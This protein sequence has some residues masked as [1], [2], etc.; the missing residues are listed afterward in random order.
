MKKLTRKINKLLKG[1]TFKPITIGMSGTEVYFIKDL[2]NFGNV[3]LKIA[4]P[5]SGI[6]LKH[7]RDVLVWLKDKLNVP[8]VIY[9]EQN[10][11]IDYLLISAIEGG[12]ISIFTAQ[13]TDNAELI[14]LVAIMAKEMRKIHETPI[15]NCPFPQ[16]LLIK[17]QEAKKRI[18][19]GLVDETD[20][21]EEN[22][23]KTANEI[24]QKLINQNIGDEDLVFTHGDFCLP[25]FIIKNKQINGIIDWERG[26]ISDRYQDIALFLRSFIFIFVSGFTECYQPVTNSGLPKRIKTIAVPAFQFEAKGLRYRVETRFTEAVMK[27]IIKRSRGLKVQSSPKGADAVVE[28]NIRDFNFTG[29]LLDSAVLSREELRTQ[30]KNGA[31]APLYLFFG[32]EKYLRDLAAKTVTDFSLR[33]SAL[34]EFNEMEFSLID[35]EFPHAIAAAE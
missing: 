30:L 24:Y 20:F 12:D 14:D 8:E 23:G 6:D 29:V 9:F 21:L 13:N 5:K 17:F 1:L 33:D 28:G 25:N 11:E 3:Y 31:I 26:G 35:T 16:N 7:E 4:S 2:P 32:A 18:E 22:L 15:I 10:E 19:N 34:R 27:E